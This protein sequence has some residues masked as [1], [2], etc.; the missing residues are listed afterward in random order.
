MSEKEMRRRDFFKKATA[1]GAAASGL[2]ASTSTV[3]ANDCYN[4]VDFRV[5]GIED[6][7]SYEVEFTNGE[8]YSGSI[9]RKEE[10]WLSV[11]EM[12]PGY[13]EYAWV[14][15]AVSIMYANSRCDCQSMSAKPDDT[16]VDISGYGDYTFGWYGDLQAEDNVEQG[17]DL[18]FAYVD[19]DQTGSPQLVF[20]EDYE[21]VFTATI[22][23]PDGH[24]AEAQF[25]TGSVYDGT[26]SYTTA[27]EWDREA[28][29]H[30]YFDAAS[31]ELRFNR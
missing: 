23:Y 10:H 31:I 30:V 6:G 9:E 13:I 5:L 17:G 24:E 3:S 29:N 25:G 27:G 16:T 12:G 1:T 8:F 7:S 20:T 4:C 11:D 2:I 15:G 14:S 19:Y 22:R 18:E 28:A 26:D 21:G